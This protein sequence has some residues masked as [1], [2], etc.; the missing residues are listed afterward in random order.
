MMKLMLR[1]F[2]FF[3]LG[4]FLLENLAETPDAVSLID[5]LYSFYAAKTTTGWSAFDESHRQLKHHTRRW[6][7]E[8]IAVEMVNFRVMWLQILFEPL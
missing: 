6:D 8:K 4:M 3:L 7:I 1:F 5:A 2:R